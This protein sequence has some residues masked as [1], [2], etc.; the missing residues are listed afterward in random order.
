MVWSCQAQGVHNGLRQATATTQMAPCH[1]PQRGAP[2]NR[3]R[4]CRQGHHHCRAPG[5]GSER[6]HQVRHPPTD[7]GGQIIRLPGPTAPG[8]PTQG[9]QRPASQASRPAASSKTRPAWPRSHAGAAWSPPIEQRHGPLRAAPPIARPAG[10]ATRL[11]PGFEARRGCGRA[12]QRPPRRAAPCR[13][14][15]VRPADTVSQARP[16]RGQ[17]ALLRGWDSARPEQRPQLP[18]QWQ[19]REPRKGSCALTAP[20]ASMKPMI[21]PRGLGR[22]MN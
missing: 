1:W 11:W 10:R 7:R 13:W 8:R 2:K 18:G 12:A 20:F 9:S 19:A 17:T 16:G 15:P 6:A 4:R 21:R 3:Q 5:R 22:P 14:M